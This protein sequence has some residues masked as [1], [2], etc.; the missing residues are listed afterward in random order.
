MDQGYILVLVLGVLMTIGM[1]LADVSARSHLGG[2]ILLNSAERVDNRLLTGGG[3]EIGI[4][5]LGQRLGGAPIGVSIPRFEVQLGGRVIAI[6]IEDECGKLNLKTAAPETMKRF[7]SEVGFDLQTA[8]KMMLSI[9]DYRGDPADKENPRPGSLE[10]L[11][12]LDGFDAS[13]MGDLARFVTVSCSSRRVSVWTAPREVLTSLP[14]SDR[15]MIDQ[16]VDDRS[17]SD[18]MKS[19]LRLNAHELSTEP[20]WLTASVG[21]VFTVRSS[22]MDDGKKSF[23][24]EQ[25][26]YIGGN[27]IANRI[28]L[29][30]TFPRTP[31]DLD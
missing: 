27:D 5:V 26:V 31:E 17:S 29:R 24:Q 1:L 4:A 2:S 6:E 18:E 21:P 20:G 22:I 14:G 25:M 15:R 7:F 9:R 13:V 10:E 11:H 3:I 19:G 16:F 8:E 12:A 23:T 30:T 28:V